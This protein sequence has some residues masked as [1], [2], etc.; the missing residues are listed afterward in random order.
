MPGDKSVSHR[1]ALIGALCDGDVTVDGFLFAEDTRA[2]LGM[3]RALGVP[4]MAEEDQGTLA[5]HGVGVEGLTEP[6]D[7]VDCA[8]SGTT[9]RLGAGLAAAV[10]GLTV[11]TGDASL[12]RRPMGRMVR[13]LEAMG[14]RIECRGGDGL[15]PLAIMGGPLRGIDHVLEVA[16][17][18]VK[19]AVLLAGLRA[20]G[21]TRVSEPGPTRDHTERLMRYLGADVAR[22]GPTISIAGG[23]RLSGRPVTVVGD[24][25]SAA[26]LLAAAA[27]TPGAEVSVSRVGLNPTRTG[28]LD[29]L[30]A[31]GALVEVTDEHDV[32]G[33]PCGSVY[34][35]GGDLRAARISGEL[36]VRA[37]DELPLVA[38]LGSRARGRTVV[39]DAGELRVKESDR[40]AVICER[41]AAMGARIEATPDGFVIDGPSTLAG[42]EVDSAGDHRI[43]MAMAVAGLVA[44]GETTI[45]GAEAAE[46]SFPGFAE[47]LADLAPGA[48]EV[49]GDR[50][51]SP[52]G[53]I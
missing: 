1:A 33:E 22:D 2:S 50:G 11:L 4:V 43:A 7:T 25:S 39:A 42:A 19:S 13:P 52:P 41:M 53:Q 10:D 18:Q 30:E 36:V 12:R 26:F 15:A 5:I 17:A 24:F 32:S 35:T 21:V 23:Q 29:V 31:F 46:V 44:D 16:S 38:I 8:N 37:I 3:V 14:A 51:P 40:I 6:E 45:R 47:V 27:V 28:L 48:I 20:H 9:M 34:V 49:G